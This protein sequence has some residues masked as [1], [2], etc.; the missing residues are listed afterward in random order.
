MTHGQ[1]DSTP[2]SRAPALDVIGAIV[3]RALDED[4]GEGD[5]T[6]ES[7][8]AADARLRGEFIAKQRGVV[9]GLEVA[10]LVLASLD[11]HQQFAQCVAD[12][13]RVEP[14][15]VIAAVEGL[16]RALLSGERTALNLLQ[17]M[18]GIATL[19]REFVDAV[20]GTRAIILDTRKTVPGLRALDKWAVRLGGGQNHRLGLYDMALIKDNHIA[21]VGGSL[22]EAVRRVRA[23][24]PR[25]RPIEVEVTNQ[26]QLGQALRLAP[27][28]DR[29]LLDNMSPDELRAAV[30]TVNGR[31]PLEASGNVSLET[32]AQVAA[33]G[34]D[35]ISIGALTHSVCALDISLE[36]TQVDGK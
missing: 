29:I 20:R 26:D 4:M 31:V 34:V 32:V 27:P 6:T 21:A 13:E 22:S 2:L 16:G 18:S 19:T 11:E 9:A 8:V 3:R 24:D 25:Q 7:T 28:V 12:G 35:Y 10:R 14:G 1:M 30:Q 36:L 23:G 17:R 15:Q 33:T 5:V